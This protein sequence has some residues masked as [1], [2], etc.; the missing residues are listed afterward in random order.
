MFNLEV[1]NEIKEINKNT[2]KKLELLK[3]VEM[4]IEIIN[5]IKIDDKI[6]NYF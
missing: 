1:E 2:F 3:F 6:N 4:L 5:C